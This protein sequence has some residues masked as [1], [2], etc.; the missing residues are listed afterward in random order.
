MKLQPL[1]AELRPLLCRERYPACLLCRQA[2]K[3]VCWFRFWDYQS[4]LL[5]IMEQQ[6]VMVEPGLFL[7]RSFYK[8]LPQ[9]LLGYDLVFYSPSFGPLPEKLPTFLGLVMALVHVS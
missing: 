8:L 7:S 3:P 2:D 9:C 6:P 1:K 4:S 5:V